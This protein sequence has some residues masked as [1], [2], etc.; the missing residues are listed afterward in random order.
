[1]TELHPHTY[2]RPP[3]LC[4]IH[5]RG[6]RALSLLRFGLLVR[7]AEL[8]LLN[9]FEGVG[10][11]CEVRVLLVRFGGPAVILRKGQDLLF[12]CDFQGFFQLRNF[13]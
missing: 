11:F 7:L 13:S 10:A 6:S 2:Q 12:S 5:P 8:E 4:Q 1:M 3:A 9:H